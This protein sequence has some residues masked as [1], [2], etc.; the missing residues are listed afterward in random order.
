[1]FLVGWRKHNWYNQWSYETSWLALG[2]IYKRLA[3]S[4]SY[5][6]CYQCSQVWAASWVKGKRS[7]K[8]LLLAS[9]AQ[10]LN[11]AVIEWLLYMF[12]LVSMTVHKHL[13]RYAITLVDNNVSFSK[14]RSGA[15]NLNI[16]VT[17]IFCVFFLLLEVPAKTAEVYDTVTFKIN[18]SKQE[19][20]MWPP[21][22][23]QGSWGSELHQRLKVVF[24]VIDNKFDNGILTM[25]MF[26]W[27]QMPHRRFSGQL[28]FII[29]LISG[30]DG[31]FPAPFLENFQIWLL[32]AFCHI[33]TME[34]AFS[35]YE[36]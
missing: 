29:F 24:V 30:G 4:W 14:L 23:I 26:H 3:S 17:S 18:E 27:M 8:I 13:L 6:V 2:C 15:C 9:N 33:C 1:M 22:C 36:Y 28:K 35:R 10:Y 25:C 21:H 5:L 20:I 16:Y 12:L 11:L 7:K 32:A 31:V 34:W 19:Q